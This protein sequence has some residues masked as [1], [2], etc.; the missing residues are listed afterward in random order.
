VLARN[1]FRLVPTHLPRRNAAGLTQAPH[2]NNRRAE[3]T[4]NCAA[5]WWQDRPLLSTA[6]T[7]RSRRSIEYGLPIHAGLP[8]SVAS[9]DEA[10]DFFD[11]V[12]GG[13]EG[14]T[15][16]DALGD[17]GEEAFDLVEP[18]GI[19]GREVNV[20]T[21]TA[22]EPSSDLG[23][24]VG[25]VVVDDEMDVEL[26]R[27]IGLDVAQEGEELLMAMAGFALG[28]DRAVEHIKVGEQR[29]CAV[30]LVVVGNAFEVAEPHGKQGYVRGPGSGSSHRRKAPQ[31]CQAD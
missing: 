4:P 20:P 21:R 7:T 2:P 25:G 12:G 15:T 26:G 6:A 8:P 18:G 29:G 9:A 30:T 17:E 3:A 11:K 27:H 13:L 31:P 10:I 22:G 24:L 16:D 19:G 23:M 1:G 28:D 5:A 14:A